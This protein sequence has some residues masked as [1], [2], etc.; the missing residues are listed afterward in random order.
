MWLVLGFFLTGVIAPLVITSVTIGGCDPRSALYILPSYIGMAITWFLP[1]SLRKGDRLN[2]PV[3]EIDATTK[4]WLGVLVCIDLISGVCHFLA[5]S[6]GGSQ[7]FILGSSASVLYTAFLSK[8]FFNRMLSWSSWLALLFI[9]VGLCF[10]A[11]FT[12][13]VGTPSIS[14]QEQQQQ[15]SDTETEETNPALGLVLTCIASFL[16]AVSALILEILLVDYDLCASAICSSIGIAGMLVY[17]TWQVFYAAPTLA[18][19]V[20]GHEESPSLLA[21]VFVVLT[22][23]STVHAMTL[24]HTTATLN[25][26]TTG[27]IRIAQGVLVF[28]LGHLLF[29]SEEERQECLTGGKALSAV[30]CMAGTAL[31]CRG[32]HRVHSKEEQRTG[33]TEIVEVV[34]RPVVKGGRVEEVPDRKMHFAL[35][36]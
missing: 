8:A 33:Y 13:G 23:N 28:F 9:V 22:I 26:T 6:F 12:C 32:A 16:H 1:L 36:T 20:M 19:N 25:C 24:M 29:C 14:I 11:H 31:Y 34:E 15:T 35:C 2:K 17:G 5:L 21:V 27:V 4:L 18:D 3:K 30:F 7:V 10:S